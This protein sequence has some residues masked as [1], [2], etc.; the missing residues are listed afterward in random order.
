MLK[1]NILI[2]ATNS[3]IRYLSPAEKKQAFVVFLLQIFASFLDV[4]GLASL[5]PVVTLASK[6]GSF[7]EHQWSSILYNAIGF[8]SETIFFISLVGFIFIFFLI[9]NLFISWIN[10]KQ[11][12]FTAS[13]ALKIIDSQYVKYI[14]LPFWKF[15]EI[16]TF[17]VVN[18]VLTVPNAYLNGIIRQMLVLLSEAVIVLIVVLGILF[19]QPTLFVI[20]AVALVPATIIT[21]KVL[22]N[23]SQE[24]GHQRDL[25]APKAYGIVSDTFAGYVELKLAHKLQLFRQRINENQALMQ[26]LDAKAYVYGLIPVRIIEMVS[27]LAVSTIIVYSLLFSDDSS[28]L[29]T[30]VGLFA[31]AAYKLMP[32]VNRILASM[33]TMKHH[34]YTLEALDAYEELQWKEHVIK[35]E[36]TISFHNQIEFDNISFTFP[37][38]T[39]PVLNG[40][41]FSIKKGEKIG[42]IGSSGSGKTTLMNLLL[43]FYTQQSGEIRAD[44]VPLRL[45][46]T[47]AWHRLVGYVKQDTFLMQAS[48]RDNITLGETDPDPQR[49]QYALEQASLADFVASLPQGLDTV[50]GERGAR[51]SGGQRQRIGIA[52]AMYKQ[53]QIL[54]MDEA[55]SALDTQTE[56]EVSE[57]INKL[58]ATD[59]TIL[60]I[61]HRITTLRQCDRIYE[62]KN[63]QIVAVHTY[64]ELI[65]RHV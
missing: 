34:L 30:I 20:L 16:G 2:E 49:L 25:Q 59:I 52:R 61:A 37:G 58:S 63:G 15:Q 47:E 11:V 33:V 48:L 29:I 10:Y 24:L 23:R 55:T 22:R 21:Y 14:G 17:E 57:A 28:N 60:I 42:F 41:S 45:D 6:P 18:E 36:Q 64:D 19:Y 8:K 65:E 13:I 32:S 56:K 62:L 5:I 38:S 44:G 39:T 53:T 27:I 46:N 43:R 1:G 3:I 26:A 35:Q 51:L 9:K 12:Q 7:K 54:V 50:S 31:A 40:V 4:F